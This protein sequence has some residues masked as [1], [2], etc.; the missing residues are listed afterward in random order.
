MWHRHL[1]LLYVWTFRPTIRQKILL[2]GQCSPSL[3]HYLWK[4]QFIL[5]CR[6]P[7]Y[8]ESLIYTFACTFNK[9]A[10]VQVDSGGT[11]L[12]I[13]ATAMWSCGDAHHF[14]YRS[15]AIGSSHSSLS[16]RHPSGGRQLLLL[17]QS[18]AGAEWEWPP[19]PG[20]VH[21]SGKYCQSFRKG[22]LVSWFV[23]LVSWPNHSTASKSAAVRWEESVSF[24][25]QR[26]KHEPK[27]FRDLAWKID[28]DFV[29]LCAVCTG[30]QRHQEKVEFLPLPSPVSPVL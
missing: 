4:T 16:R 14:T 26:H 10:H 25:L 23:C 3:P 28:V 7:V 11:R 24:R 1:Y 6:S 22:G 29:P 12:R 8:W 19:A 17:T 21:T 27:V 15:L 20:R 18:Q 5:S 13:K 2:H 30:G 9:Y